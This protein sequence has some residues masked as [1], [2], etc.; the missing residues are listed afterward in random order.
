MDPIHH[1]SPAH[2]HR[3]AE[4]LHEVGRWLLARQR[5]AD[6]AAVARAMVRFA[7]HDERGWLTLGACHE[8]NDQP[9][10]ALEMYGVGRVLAAPAPRCEL[11][12]ARAFRSRAMFADAREAYE[13]AATAAERVADEDLI[14]LI[15]RER[16]IA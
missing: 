15:E 12:R 13:L 6:A 1:G 5:Y 3:A 10:L 16:T 8:G 14:Q 4:A 7:P 11:A 9:D 2:S